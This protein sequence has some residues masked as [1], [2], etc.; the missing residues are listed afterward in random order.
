MF[1]QLALRCY[2]TLLLFA[3]QSSFNCQLPELDE[4]GLEG[5]GLVSGNNT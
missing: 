5:K 4:T 3:E 2:V 1:A